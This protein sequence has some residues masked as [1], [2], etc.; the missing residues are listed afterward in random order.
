MVGTTAATRATATTAA[1]AAAAASAAPVA[2]SSTGN[3]APC[4]VAATGPHAAA[5]ALSAAAAVQPSPASATVQP[6][7]AAAASTRVAWGGHAV[8]PNGQSARSRPGALHNA[9]LR[10]PQPSWQHGAAGAAVGPPR[11]TARTRP[12]ARLVFSKRLQRCVAQG[13]WSIF[14]S[15]SSCVRAVHLLCQDLCCTTQGAPSGEGLLARTILAILDHFGA[16]CLASHPAGIRDLGPKPF[17]ATSVGTG[18]RGSTGGH[19]Q[20]LWPRVTLRLAVRGRR[21][22]SEPCP[23]NS[24]CPAEPPRTGACDCDG[25][26]TMWVRARTPPRACER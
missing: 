19:T 11:N 20:A 21:R 23:A 10:V 6:R 22:S 13:L 24:S 9:G 2:P 3:G 25:L 8:P 12:R 16:E 18:V 15:I 14:S 7:T 17:R 5:A 26:I 1:V 4:T